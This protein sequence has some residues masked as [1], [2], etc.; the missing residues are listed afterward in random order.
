MRLGRCHPH[1]RPAAGLVLL[2][3]RHGVLAGHGVLY[4]VLG[5][6]FDLAY[7]KKNTLNVFSHSLI[8]RRLK[9]NIMYFML[10]I[11]FFAKRLQYDTVLVVKTVAIFTSYCIF[12]DTNRTVSIV[13]R[14]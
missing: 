12:Y 3:R 10:R 4:G 13:I 8:C 2:T 1:H 11:Y 9:R 14:Y 7:S 6:S 5:P